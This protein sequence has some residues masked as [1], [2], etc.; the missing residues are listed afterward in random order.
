MQFAAETYQ[1]DLFVL[2]TVAGKQRGKRGRLR[3]AVSNTERSSIIDRGVNHGF[4]S[5]VQGAIFPEACQ[6]WII[7]K[8]SS[9]GSLPENTRECNV[10]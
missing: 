2:I 6:C 7:L 10:M 9:Q 8:K 5:W 3:A 4:S 1:G